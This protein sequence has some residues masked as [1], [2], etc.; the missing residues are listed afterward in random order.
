MQRFVPSEYGCDV[1]LAE[2]MLE[3]AKSILGAKFESV[4]LSEQQG[5]L[6]P[7]SLATGCKASCFQGRG[8]LK[9]TVLRTTA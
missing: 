3:P 9:Q 6:T 5:S 2:H 7:S 1:E 8:T 4:K